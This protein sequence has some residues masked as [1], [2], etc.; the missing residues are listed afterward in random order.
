MF[1][2]N[3]DRME[4]TRQYETTSLPL[5]T[6]IRYCEGDESH[7]ATTRGSHGC[8]FTFADFEK[9][10]ELHKLYFG[11]PV[12]IGDVRALLDVDRAIRGTIRLCDQSGNGVWKLGQ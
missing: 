12:A 3:E 7:I 4:L 6:F 8:F 11:Q 10:R 2:G 5:A 1:P 9:C